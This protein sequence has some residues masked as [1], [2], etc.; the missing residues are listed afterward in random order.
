V[1]AVRSR[2]TQQIEHGRVDPLKAYLKL[3]AE[4]AL[5]YTSSMCISSHY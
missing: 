3:Q 2:L 4:A 5:E 1:L